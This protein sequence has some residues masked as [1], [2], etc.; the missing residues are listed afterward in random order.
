MRKTLTIIFICAGLVL[1]MIACSQEG[2]DSKNSGLNVQPTALQET[3][4]EPR[5]ITGEEALEL[6]GIGEDEELQA[7]STPVQWFPIKVWVNENVLPYDPN[8]N[9]DELAVFSRW[10]LSDTGTWLGDL[11]SGTEVTLLNISE[12]G[13]SCLV[14][15]LAIQGWSVKGWVAC[16]RLDFD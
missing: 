2:N 14:D 5:V 11:K 12:N 6:Y 16:N 9:V 8:E 4:R 10:E 13:T 1:S 15:G 3:A 7:T